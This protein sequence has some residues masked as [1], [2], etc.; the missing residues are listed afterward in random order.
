MTPRQPS[1]LPRLW[2]GADHQLRTT[3]LQDQSHA[4]LVRM[5]A[6]LEESARKP[7]KYPERG[8]GI[9]VGDEVDQ[10]ALDSRQP[11]ELNALP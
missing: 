6:A 3:K 7:V 8:V 9:S 2:L 1:N 5:A 4:S 11:Q 10:A